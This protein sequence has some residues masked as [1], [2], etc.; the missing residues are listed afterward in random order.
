[1]KGSGAYP[2]GLCQCGCGE[3]TNPAT[4][5]DHRR[6]NIKGRPQKFVSGHS[7]R[8]LGLPLGKM[9]SS[10]YIM[11]SE[12]SHP[13]TNSK[14]Y[15]REH[16]VI[17]EKALGKSLP[18]GVI[19]HHANE[20]RSDNR[21]ENLV[22]CP[23]DAYHLLLHARIR[24]KSICGNPDWRPCGYCGEYDDLKNLRTRR[25]GSYQHNRCANAYLRNLRMRKK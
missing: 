25:R 10:G 6:G 18:P 15:V 24:A 17:A 3:R 19:V 2:L 23:D 1:M 8:S 12:P 4:Q 21:N 11:I 5:T 13:R 22:I 9:F 20:V 14:G 7:R 16:I